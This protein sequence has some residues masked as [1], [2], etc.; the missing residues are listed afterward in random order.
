MTTKLYRVKKLGEHILFDKA[1]SDQQFL[2]R[3]CSVIVI[4]NSLALRNYLEIYLLELNFQLLTV[5]RS[6][7]VIVLARFF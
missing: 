7:T 4:Y 2:Y 3:Q 6:P 1:F 5:L